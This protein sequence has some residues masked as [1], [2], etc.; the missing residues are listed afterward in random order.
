[1]AP[2]KQVYAGI[3]TAL[4]DKITLLIKGNA[5][6]IGDNTGDQTDAT[7]P[8]SDITTNNASILKHGFLPKLPNSTLVYLNGVGLWAIPAG[9]GVATLIAVAPII[10]VGTALNPILAFQYQTQASIVAH[11][12]GG[13]VS[14]T[15]LLAEFNSVDIVANALDSVM[16]LAATEGVRQYV[17]N[18]GTNNLDIYPQVGQ[19]IKGKAINVPLML[20]PKNGVTFTCYVAS[21]S[22][23]GTFRFQ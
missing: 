18:G 21:P 15:K 11:S 13:Q 4:K 23:I 8:F 2:F 19:Y 17:Y 3:V 22:E 1:M 5:S 14:A 7:L 10:N 6:I 16:L 12:G 9:T 20:M